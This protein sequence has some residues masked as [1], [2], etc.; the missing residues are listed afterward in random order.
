MLMNQLFAVIAVFPTLTLADAQ[1]ITVWEGDMALPG[2]T[3]GSA[4][5]I[6]EADASTRKRTGT[7]ARVLERTSISTP[8]GI[9]F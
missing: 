3:G 2:T 4:H 1:W 9:H 8:H 5:V 6:T 7:M